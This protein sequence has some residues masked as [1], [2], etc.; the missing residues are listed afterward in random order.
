MAERDNGLE[1]TTVPIFL[2]QQTL[3]FIWAGAT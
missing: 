3:H 1:V 2:Q